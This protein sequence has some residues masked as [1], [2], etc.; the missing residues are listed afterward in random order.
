LVSDV[1]FIDWKQR[2]KDE[3]E[4]LYD[5]YQRISAEAFSVM[6]I[7]IETRCRLNKLT[8]VDATHLYPE[9]RKRYISI[10]KNNHV[11]IVCVVLDLDQNVLLERDKNRENP[12]GNKRI[13]Q[14]YQVFKREKRFIKKE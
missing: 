2:P 13:K 14:Q 8:F 11:P 10:A 12:R 3:A 1:E 4:G 5:Q 7:L 9:D 6:D